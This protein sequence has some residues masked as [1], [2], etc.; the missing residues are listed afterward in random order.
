MEEKSFEFRSEISGGIHLA[1]RSFP[2]GGPGLAELVVVDEIVG[3]ID[4]W[5]QVKQVL[6]DFPNG[7][8]GVCVEVARNK[9][10]RFIELSEYGGGGQQTFVFIL[11]GRDRRGWGD[12]IVQMKRLKNHYENKR[13]DV[14]KIGE[15]QVVSQMVQ[16]ERSY[17]AVLEGNGQCLKRKSSGMGNPSISGG[18]TNMGGFGRKEADLT[19][20][21]HAG[22]VGLTKLVLEGTLNM[23]PLKN[24]L[25]SL[26]NEAE[27]WQGL[28]E[29]GLEVKEADIRRARRRFIKEI[30]R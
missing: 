22:D 23:Q 8:H 29:M 6:E 27:R 18:E 4:Q 3:S 24:I 11:E 14:N 26:K 9:H 1:E 2:R 12:C 21:D 19:A 30:E 20:G 7:K 15:M 5:R 17:A 13:E 16:G 10:G 25:M 28:L